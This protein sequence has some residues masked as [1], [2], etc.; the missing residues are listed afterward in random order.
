MPEQDLLNNS[1]IKG[2]RCGCAKIKYSHSI[3][4]QNTLSFPGRKIY[5]FRSKN[6]QTI[7]NGAYSP[8]F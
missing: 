4:W 2:N 8:K 5:T 1:L 7:V 3:Y 6:F